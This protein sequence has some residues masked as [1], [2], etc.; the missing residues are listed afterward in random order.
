VGGA[1]VLSSSSRALLHLFLPDL[2]LIAFFGGIGAMSGA[3]N[4]EVVVVG[5]KSYKYSSR[6]RTTN[7][8]WQKCSQG[9]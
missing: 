9:S 5:R 2:D 3:A 7:P 1:T 6:Q 4:G 8:Q